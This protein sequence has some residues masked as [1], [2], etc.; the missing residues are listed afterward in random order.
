MSVSFR[1]YPREASFEH[2]V[3]KIITVAET[4]LNSPTRLTQT[5]DPHLKAGLIKVNSN[6]F[7]VVETQKFDVHTSNPVL[8]LRVGF[9]T[10]NELNDALSELDPGDIRTSEEAYQ[11]RLAYHDTYD[12]WRYEPVM[13]PATFDEMH[14]KMPKLMAALDALPFHVSAQSLPQLK[15][16]LMQIVQSDNQ[17]HNAINM[18]EA[19]L[20]I[21]GEVIDKWIMHSGPTVQFTF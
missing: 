2:I 6:L 20:H 16:K 12:E 1:G 3:D 11:I 18:K 15:D 21:R 8:R 7:L 13:D 10:V 4:V 19:L 9:I 14:G 5:I 17:S